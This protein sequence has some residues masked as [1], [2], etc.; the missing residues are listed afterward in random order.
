MYYTTSGTLTY[1]VV[2]IRKA[3][4]GFEADLRMIARLTDTWSMNLVENVFHDIVKL[5][6]AKYLAEVSIALEDSYGN[7]V[8]AA[9][10]VVNANGTAIS[11]AR[12]G[13]NDWRPIP[14]TTLSAILSYTAEWEKLTSHEK[15]QFQVNNDFLA[16]WSS[17]NIDTSFP[18]LSRAAGQ[19]YA[20]NGFELQKYNYR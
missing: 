9:K 19:L 3:F 18:H 13:G 6:E 20:S 7:P 12:P 11:S 17:T 4:E 5:A 1:T 14:Q 15:E 8:R 10:Y 16:S 2:D